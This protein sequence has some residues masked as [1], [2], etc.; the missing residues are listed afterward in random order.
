V[1]TGGDATLAVSDPA[2]ASA[3]K[4]VNGSFTMAQPLQLNATS[5]AGSGSPL[6]PLGADPLTLLSYGGPVSNDQV[7]V[8]LKQPVAASD[9]LRTGT[10]SKT[11]VFTLSTTSP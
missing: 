4:L 1:S 9:P 8:N 6:A 10:Y 7:T 3:G 5:A 2:T 11:L